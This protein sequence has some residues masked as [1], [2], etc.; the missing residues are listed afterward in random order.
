MNC[1]ERLAKFDKFKQADVVD[2]AL[3]ALAKY[4]YV[5]IFGALILALEEHEDVEYPDGEYFTA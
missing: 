2:T 4:R 3:T 5:G 1:L